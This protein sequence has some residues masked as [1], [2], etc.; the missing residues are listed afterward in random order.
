MNQKQ[1]SRYPV[2]SLAADSENTDLKQPNQQR[3]NNMGHS[4]KQT[5]S[6]KDIK[7]SR[8]KDIKLSSYNKPVALTIMNSRKVEP[9]AGTCSMANLHTMHGTWTLQRECEKTL[10][11]ANRIY[12][13]CNIIARSASNRIN[14]KD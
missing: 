9:V 3:Q 8:Y 7:L 6:N 13:I 5:I 10:A 4:F 1:N 11:F 2:E 14:K 12:S